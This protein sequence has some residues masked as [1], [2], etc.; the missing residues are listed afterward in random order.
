MQT[1][2]G[3]GSRPAAT[4]LTIKVRPCKFYGTHHSLDAAVDKVA[5]LQEVLTR[6]TAGVL[7]TLFALMD[8]WIIVSV[9]PPVSC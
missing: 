9:K 3:V 6:G 4:E 2:L 5:D 1:A 7:S 8:G